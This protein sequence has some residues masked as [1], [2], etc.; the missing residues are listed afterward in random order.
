MIIA[1]KNSKFTI[2]WVAKD[3][4]PFLILGSLSCSASWNSASLTSEV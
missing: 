4:A 3:S 1:T 2:S